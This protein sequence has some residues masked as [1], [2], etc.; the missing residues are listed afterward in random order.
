MRFTQRQD[1]LRRLAAALLIAASSAVANWAAVKL[2]G[3][4]LQTSERVAV[5]GLVFG[6]VPVVGGASKL[7]KPP[8]DTDLTQVAQRLA[9]T[10]E[11]AEL[12]QRTQLLSGDNQ[13]LD[14]SFALRPAPSRV[15]AGAAPSGTLDGITD[16]YRRLSPRRLLI[17]GAPGAGKT[18]LA[19]ELMLGL[20]E[21][22]GPD[23]AVPIRLSLTSWDTACPLE[24]WLT[25]E[26]T[27]TYELT[28]AI[29]RRMVEERRILPVLD[30]LDEMDPPDEEVAPSRAARALTALNRYQ[31]GRHKAA[32]IVTSRTTV[33]EQ[34]A[35]R[36]RLLDAAHVE[37][38]PV[39]TDQAQA[40]MDARVQDPQQ[41]RPVIE[42]AR[43]SPGSAVTSMLST[44]W[45]LT[46]ALTAYEAE[47]D[48]SELLHFT[49]RDDL[50]NHLLHRFVPAATALHTTG[51]R[52]PYRLDQVEHWLSV[53]ARYLDDNTRT[54]RAV[55]GQ[56]LSGTDIMPHR[57]WPLAGTRTRV[58]DTAISSISALL[59]LAWMGSLSVNDRTQ[60]PSSLVIALLAIGWI[61]A[62]A[63]MAWPVP[64][65][66]DP[67]R[68]R[69][70]DGRRAVIGP[71]AFGAVAALALALTS[72]LPS[73]APGLAG[74]IAQD[75]ALLL[76]LG[77][78]GGLAFGLRHNLEDTAQSSKYRG[79]ADLVR[80]D[81]CAGLLVGFTAGCAASL[82]LTIPNIIAY[83]Q[84]QALFSD[85]LEVIISAIASGTALA[86]VVST[87]WAGAWR[88][89]IATVLCTRGRLPWRINRF[90]AWAYTAGILR[91]SGSAYQFRH[92]ELQDHLAQR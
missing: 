78:V 55:S 76:P 39:T 12:A 11:T 59:L 74:Y 89:Y 56:L 58:I 23:D 63:K 79:P 26:L 27:Q 68:L 80:A 44:P 43:R 2:V 9:I 10:V 33:Y 46:L 92:R 22:R 65:G 6:L 42:H 87:V 34:L 85:L 25:D 90:L 72:A 88:R 52:P 5:F 38:Q 32:L 57:I 24:D 75:L 60:I 7:L 66:I 50:R 48:P 61:I 1:R 62:A 69:T 17:S 49:D 28:K 47:G 29:A 16:Y 41:W 4:G 19:L 86:I 83:G 14:V 37:I 51:N 40:F 82:G 31:V 53:L 30:G 67:G 45:L 81:L 13:P 71:V 18:V 15:A 64:K 3:G 73:P 91:M 35:R 70:P 8:D 36:T 21:Q 84:D 54:P 77:L 20:L